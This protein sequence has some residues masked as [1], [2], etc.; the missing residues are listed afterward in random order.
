VPLGFYSPDVL[1]PAAEGALVAKFPSD[2]PMLDVLYLLA[3]HSVFDSGGKYHEPL[4]GVIAV[5]VGQVVATS[6]TSPTRDPACESSGPFSREP[7]DAWILKGQ[8]RTRNP[9]HGASS[10]NLLQKWAGPVL[11]PAPE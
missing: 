11:Q 5:L 2:Y 3:I 7:P 9:S 8:A 4:M 6:A 10:E 1:C